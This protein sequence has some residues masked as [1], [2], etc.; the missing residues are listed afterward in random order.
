MENEIAIE[1]HADLISAVIATIFTPLEIGDSIITYDK[2]TIYN[3]ARL[4]DNACRTWY[5]V[6]LD[7][8]DLDMKL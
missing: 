5:N 3:L 1:S 4:L 8:A 7:V 6:D 2:E